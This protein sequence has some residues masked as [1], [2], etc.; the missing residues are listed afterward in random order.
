M[1]GRRVFVER[2]LFFLGVL[3]C[4]I[5]NVAFLWGEHR[6]KSEKTSAEYE[7][8][9]AR[10]VKEYDQKYL[11]IRNRVQANPG[12]SIFQREDS[13]SYKNQLKTLK[14]YEKLSGAKVAYGHGVD[15]AVDAVWSFRSFSGTCVIFLFLV[16]LALTEEKRMEV[17]ILFFSLPK[18]RQNY[19]VKKVAT[20]GAGC[21]VYCFVTGIILYLSSF[22]IY[23]GWEDLLLPLSSVERFRDLTE[24]WSIGGYLLFSLFQRVFFLW[25]S[26]LFFLNLFQAFPGRKN[27]AMIVGGVLA[28][29]YLMYRL[30]PP[31]SRFQLLKY[32]NMFAFFFPEQ[33]DGIY[34]NLS[35]FGHLI[36][37]QPWIRLVAV[38]H[39]GIWLPLLI[40]QGG[41]RPEKVAIEVPFRKTIDH[42]HRRIRSWLGSW[43][44]LFL[45]WWKTLFVEKGIWV[46]LAVVVVIGFIRPLDYVF[47]S[48][49]TEFRHSFYERF[50]GPVSE[51]AR[52]Y[53]NEE[54]DKLNQMMEEYQILLQD[55][56]EGKVEKHEMEQKQY[57][58]SAYDPER[59][60]LEE[61]QEQI[62][63]MDQTE[64]L[65]GI[66]PWLI[67][68]EGFQYLSGN[69]GKED[70]TKRI[71]LLLA[72]AILLATGDFY[73]D[74][75]AGLYSVL[76]STKKG[77]KS[78]YCRKVFFYWKKILV[79]FVLS[80]A[81]YT[82]WIGKIYGLSFGNAPIQSLEE[83]AY[84]PFYVTIWNFWCITLASE[85]F[86]LMMM[87]GGIYVCA[88]SLPVGT[89]LLVSCLLYLLPAFGIVV[90]FI[91]SDTGSVLSLLNISSQIAG[92]PRW[93][94]GAFWQLEEWKKWLISYGIWYVIWIGVGIS[95]YVLSCRKWCV[96]QE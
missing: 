12:I 63:R 19:M 89:G 94:D 46:F 72:A 95:G 90:G 22:L 85:L 2:K 87:A 58:V 76:R 7:E 66:Q 55:A 48:P 60:A 1:E 81:L 36:R 51:E 34:R 57:L 26:G 29:E 38:L 44:L 75:K 56:L 27:A 91:K 78:Y 61:L 73:H 70:R 40:M 54:S 11:E 49:V 80:E 4:I 92:L 39:A 62:R 82:I 84:L 16:V 93:R 74:K 3:L 69:K 65:T 30:F 18:G 20:L 6:N 71:C 68:T 53:I 50:P 23:G 88:A 96:A 10:Y 83:F 24:M 64:E 37:V 35:L 77:R 47:Y 31:Q 9:H 32:G 33:T 59:R 52:Q 28:V 21:L 43:P 41:R 14:D 13:F 17:D 45:D 86:C 79:V 8:N 42:I 25:S 15:L 5:C 67:K